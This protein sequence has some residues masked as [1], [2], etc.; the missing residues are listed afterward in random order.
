MNPNKYQTI[1][2]INGVT[3]RTTASSKEPFNS[4]GHG[5]NDKGSWSTPP[6]TYN[7]TGTTSSFCSSFDAKVKDPIN[8]TQT[9]RTTYDGPFAQRKP[10]TVKNCRVIGTFNAPDV[11][12]GIYERTYN[13]HSPDRK[14]LFTHEMFLADN[15]KRSI[16]KKVSI[17]SKGDTKMY[18]KY[19][20]NVR[21]HK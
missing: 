2:T 1:G 6:A 12:R 13:E 19:T 11:K 3:S 4:R 5:K 21:E 9:I 14:E 10:T 16:E 8:R 20:A 15:G 18:S 17:F 7:H